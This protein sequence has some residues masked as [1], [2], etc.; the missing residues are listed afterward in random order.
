VSYGVGGLRLSLDQIE[1]G[2]LRGNRR[3]LLPPWR[4][5]GRHDPRVALALERPDPRIHFA[6]PC[7]APSCRPVGV[8]R[9]PLVDEQL[10]LAT[11]NFVNQEVVLD[12]QGRI[13][14]PKTFKWYRRDFEGESTLVQ[15]LSRY[16]DEGPVKA[17]LA[18][19]VRPRLAFR[20]Y[21]WGLQHPAA[22]TQAE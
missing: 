4:P 10:D 21:A 3:R 9:A 11:G 7:G 22:G 18:A 13:E 16:L 15:F 20:P 6:I 8:Y 19:S 5:F 1:H 2:I 14:C 17:A 12:S